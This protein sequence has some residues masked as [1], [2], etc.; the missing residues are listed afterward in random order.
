MALDRKTI[1]KQYYSNAYPTFLRSQGP[2]RV[3]DHAINK[4]QNFVQNLQAINDQAQ[5]RFE[6]ECKKIKQ[7]RKFERE[8][9]NWQ[10]KKQD[11][12]ALQNLKM[13]RQNNLNNLIDLAR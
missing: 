2:F 12:L 3:Y 6:E 4:G 9:F 5:K 11:I 8:E 10:K 1:S 13:R 7:I